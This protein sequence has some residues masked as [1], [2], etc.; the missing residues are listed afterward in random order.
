MSHH[1]D[2][3]QDDPANH[4][5]E[6]RSFWGTPAGLGF[7]ALPGIPGLLLCTEH[8][9]HLFGALP[10]VVTTILLTL[11]AAIGAGLSRAL[12]RFA[13]SERRATPSAVVF[14]AELQEVYH[15]G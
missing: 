7:V 12:G 6:G 8:R 2:H 1:A 13:L 3:Q 5:S 10:F 11:G 14:S 4:K 15:A 9:A